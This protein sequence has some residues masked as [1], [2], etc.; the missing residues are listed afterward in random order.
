[1]AIRI[2]RALL[3][4]AALAGAALLLVRLVQRRLLYF[5]ER[6]A[7]AEAEQRARALG[8]EP[9]IDGGE[10]L[11]WRARTPGARG[12]LLV[13]HGNAGS[14]L[15][16]AYFAAAFAAAAPDLPLE[17]LLAEYPGYGPRPGEPSEPALLAAARAAITAARR[18]GG[19][20]LVAGESLGSA[21]AALAAAADPAAVDG[22]LLVTPLASV[23]AVARRHYPF[24]PALAHRDTWRADLAL[25]RYGGRVAFLVAGKDEVVFADLG[26]ALHD[27][28]P[29]PK[30]LWVDERATHNGV[31]WRPS[32][33]RW[34]EIVLFLAPSR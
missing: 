33:G 27:A 4:L 13:F 23:P 11:G 7:R 31:G 8:L 22:L 32:L 3:L 16:R 12:R 6:T 14:A 30:R 17:V 9:W 18:E 15:D 19:P 25:P 34:G 5:P 10:L 26:R 20:L 1:M 24:V 29:G 2:V 28:Y 21:V